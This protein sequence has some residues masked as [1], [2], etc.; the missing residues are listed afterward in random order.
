MDTR[1]L[2]AMQEILEFARAFQIPPWEIDAEK[3]GEWVRVFREMVHHE[4]ERERTERRRLERYT[5][6]RDIQQRQREIVRFVAK[7]HAEAT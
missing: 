2:M 3:H 1:R 5:R 6:L 4:R 7:E